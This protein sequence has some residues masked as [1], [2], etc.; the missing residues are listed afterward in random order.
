MVTESRKRI[1]IVMGVAAC[2]KTSFGRRLAARIGAEF[3][4]GDDLHP[5]A[6]VRKMTAGEPLDD[7]DRQP[8]LEALRDRAALAAANNGSLVIACSALRRRYR[9]LIR[10]GAPD[11]WFAYLQ[12]DEDLVR[13]RIGQRQGHFMKADMVASQFETLEPPVDEP[14]TLTLDAALSLDQLTAEFLA[15]DTVTRTRL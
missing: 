12:A 3:I 15:A 13:D 9:D 5:A 2:G 7:V 10:T 6:N 11:A 8:W 14:N 4:D 1:V